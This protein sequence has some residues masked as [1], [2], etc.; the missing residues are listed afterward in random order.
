MSVGVGGCGC[1]C[2]VAVDPNIAWI[3]W[4]HSRTPDLTEADLV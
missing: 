2:V 4:D 1:G 3:S